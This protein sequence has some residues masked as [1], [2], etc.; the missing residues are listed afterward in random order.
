[1]NWIEFWVASACFPTFWVCSASLPSCGGY[2]LFV[3]C[4]FWVC[5]AR[6]LEQACQTS[7]KP[8]VLQ[9]A[10]LYGWSLLRTSVPA[11]FDLLLQIPQQFRTAKF[12]KISAKF[13]RKSVSIP[14]NSATFRKKSTKF[15]KSRNKSAKIL[16]ILQKI[17]KL[18]QISAKFSNKS[19][20]FHKIRKFLVKCLQ[21]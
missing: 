16:N 11:R 19:A 4:F 21:R 2:L 20:K 7:G 5:S 6:F 18:P 1:M 13:R 8:L 10:N 14:Q 9:V 3:S 17:R 15:R 12:R